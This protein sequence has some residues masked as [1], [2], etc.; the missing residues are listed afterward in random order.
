ML[1]IVKNA[2]P[3]LSGALASLK[4]QTFKDFE[5]VVADGASTDGTLE[6]LRAAASDLP[7]DVVSEP[8]R[9]LADGFAKALRR[10]RGDFVGML[11]ADERYYPNTLQQVLDWFKAY[12]DAAMCG[13]K[14]DFIDE[15]DKIVGSHLTAP[16][17]LAAHLACELVP[18]N[19]SS[20]FNLP[21]IGDD[22]RFDADVPSCP[23]YEFWARL[24][25]RFA[26]SAFH[27][28]DVSVAQAYRTRASMSFRAESFSQ[29]CRDKLTHLNNIL[30]DDYTGSEIDPVRRRSSA[31]IH[32]WA[33]EQLSGIEP[34]HP[35]ILAH[36]AAAAGYDKSYARIE[37]FISARK[38]GRYDAASGIVRRNTPGPRVAILDRLEPI[39][40]PSYWPGAA[41]L[42][43]DPLTLRTAASPWGFSL[44]M[45]APALSGNAEHGQRWARLELEVFD[46]SVGISMV[47]PDQKLYGERVF[48]ATAGRAVA[49][50]PLAAD[51][52]SPAGVMVRSGGHASST[53]RI[54]QADLLNDP[55]SDAVAPLE[56]MH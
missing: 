34:D 2:V 28:H 51:S 52:A 15:T 10:A 24:G 43:F 18:S 8:D 48:D 21:L 42:G 38:Q 40:T 27:R 12:P 54:F 30:A 11:C 56:V 47:T 26:A 4:E 14:V 36:G 44:E 32:M 9:S 1:L 17:N 33:A 53:V 16:F 29:F 7:L 45:V 22:F 37:R 5:V 31:G 23:D 20:F 13:G 50:I 46:G 55:D 19:L 25:I 39:A 6:V 35:D 3:L 41:I 49:L